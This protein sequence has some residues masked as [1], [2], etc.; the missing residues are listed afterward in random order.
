MSKQGIWWQGGARMQA[1]W[2]GRVAAHRAEHAH[3]FSLLGARVLNI[4]SA[5]RRLAASDEVRARSTA[6]PRQRTR[7]EAILAHSLDMCLCAKIASLVVR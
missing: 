3:L 7:P 4:L 1:E 6:R 5:N 2:H